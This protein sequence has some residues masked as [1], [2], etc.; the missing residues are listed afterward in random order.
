MSL[1]VRRKPGRPGLMPRSRLDLRP[2]GDRMAD[3]SAAGRVL[4]VED[5]EDAARTLAVCLELH[6]FEVCIARNA[7]EALAAVAEFLPDA[8]I[9][10]L[11][12]PK[13]DGIEVIRRVRSAHPA[14]RVAV[15]VLTGFGD[16]DRREAANR[17]GA[18]AFLLKPTDPDEVADWLRRLC[19]GAIRDG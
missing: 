4:I 2:L 13:V 18:D 5:V 6:G 8:L 1:L 10:D 11:G 19:G 15:V 3:D 12:L 16:P 9:V 7:D 17:V 14:G